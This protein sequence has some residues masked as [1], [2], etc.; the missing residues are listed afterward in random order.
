MC[1]WLCLCVC[2]CVGVCAG[3]CAC[4]WLRV[5]VHILMFELRFSTENVPQYILLLT[6]QPNT[7]DELFSWYHFERWE[8]THHRRN[9][10]LFRD[11]NERCNLQHTAHRVF[12]FF[13]IQSAW[14]LPLGFKIYLQRYNLKQEVCQVKFKWD[15]SFLSSTCILLTQITYSVPNTTCVAVSNIESKHILTCKCGKMSP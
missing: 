1:L 14:K 7:A 13:Y 2:V 11:V 8:F 6:T 3:V 9:T 12:S 5:W 4:A 15:T 10:W